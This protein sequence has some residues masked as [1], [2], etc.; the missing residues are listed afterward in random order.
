M[1]NVRKIFFPIYNTDTTHVDDDSD[2]LL[3]YIYIGL[4][5]A[6]LG[7]S[8]IALPKSAHSGLHPPRSVGRAS[9]VNANNPLFYVLLG[10]CIG[11]LSAPRG[12]RVGK[13]WITMT[14]RRIVAEQKKGNQVCRRIWALDSMT[15]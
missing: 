6:F 4:S 5:I 12:L 1:H 9:P 13:E 2:F 14:N 15:S 11:Y 8:Y 7:K 10:V 3:P